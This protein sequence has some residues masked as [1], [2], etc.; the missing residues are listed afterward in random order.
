MDKDKM[1][2]GMS[3]E[4]MARHIE[5]LMDGGCVDMVICNC[6]NSYLSGMH[7]E[8]NPGIIGCYPIG[9]PEP[10]IHT[11]ACGS[12]TVVT[13]NCDCGEVLVGQIF[14]EHGG[15]CGMC[16]PMNQNLKLTKIIHID[17]K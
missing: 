3:S 15:E 2:E 6:G 1:R 13:Y 8:I 14:P 11:I 5:D 17:N 7:G 12:A 9:C 4:E 16:V 10:T